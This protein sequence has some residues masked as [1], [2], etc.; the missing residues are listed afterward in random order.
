[1]LDRAE[2]PVRI[3]QHD[4]VKILMLRL[5]EFPDL[6][7][8]QVQANRGDG[9]LEFVSDRVQKTV[10]LLV[11]VNFANQKNRVNHDSR[12][13]QGEK[14]DSENQRN[15]FPPLEDN[16]GD[17]Q[18]QRQADQAGAQGHEKR[19]FFGTSRNAHPRSLQPL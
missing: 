19:D 10:L 17:V 4:P 2:K 13:D 15:D 5:G 12:D 18:R 8:F 16:P 14:N 9:S 11:F 3:L 7:R 1:M 6:Q